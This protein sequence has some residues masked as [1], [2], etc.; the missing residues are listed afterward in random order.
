[1]KNPI[2]SVL[3]DVITVSFRDL[4]IDETVL[5]D[6]SKNEIS[7]AIENQKL[8]ESEQDLIEKIYIEGERII[9]YEMKTNPSNFKY[10]FPK[11]LEEQILYLKSIT[12]KESGEKSLD[13]LLERI[14]SDKYPNQFGLQSSA[15]FFSRYL[16]KNE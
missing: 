12:I 1:M 2:F 16:S 10:T 4:I 9:A 7:S 5:D 14:R 15:F 3:K 8:V 13:G 6:F 11:Y